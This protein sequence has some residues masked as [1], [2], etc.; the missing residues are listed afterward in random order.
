MDLCVIVV[1]SVSERENAEDL[2]AEIVVSNSRAK[3]FNAALFHYKYGCP[4]EEDML[5][6][7]C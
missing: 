4:N 3:G 7:F 6:Q 2:F 5:V 1:T